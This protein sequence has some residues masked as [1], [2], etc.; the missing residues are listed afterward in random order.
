MK[1]YIFILAAA[2]AVVACKKEQ[3]VQQPVEGK[4]IEFTAT[5]EAPV[6]G[7]VAT[8]GAFTWE[9]GDVAAVYT[10]NG[11]KLD[12]AISNISGATATFTATV[13]DGDAVA[14]GAIVV[15]PASIY[16]ASGKVT[17]PASYTDGKG[18]QG[19]ALVAKVASGNL[20]FKYLTGAIS[21]SISDVPAIATSVSVKTRDAADVADVVCTG[22]YDVDFSG[23]NPALSNP[24]GT[25]SA[26]S[27]TG[28]SEG[29]NS[30]VLPILAGEQKVKLAV[31]YNEDV[32][33]EKAV[34]LTATRNYYAAMPALSINPE[35][36]I[37]ADRIGWNTND[38]PVASL[39][40]TV[41]SA[42]LPVLGK[43]YFRAIVKYGNVEVNYGLET[44]DQ[45][46]AASGNLKVGYDNAVY[47]EYSGMYDIT[48]DYITGAYTLAKKATSPL[49]MIGVNGT[50]AFD[51]STNGFS[52]IENTN[53]LYWK[54]TST[55]NNFK[56]YEKGITDYNAYVYG[57]S[58]TGNWFGTFNADTAGGQDCGMEAN[59]EGVAVFDFRG[60]THTW[61]K[62]ADNA[63][64][65]SIRGDFAA[66][67]AD[68]WQASGEISFEEAVAGTGIW[69][70]NLTLD[71]PAQLKFVVNGN[72]WFGDGQNMNTTP[73]F[74]NLTNGSNNMTLA[75]GTYDIY[76]VA[77]GSK[78]YHVYAR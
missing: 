9:A 25:G 29:A 44:A 53:L 63:T 55:T 66:A 64:S 38:A 39:S 18:L 58:A 13:P 62:T 19:P 20:A 35:V 71:A 22:T 72:D 50:W 7:L 31:K 1:K 10:E 74:I 11:V 26:I 43:R 68:D 73:D 33:L 40:G 78:S 54:G 4:T 56:V 8:G 60:T 52:T 16:G 51:S 30:F 48:F 12:L 37:V 32:L 47:V 2:A 77:N 17:F 45:P 5:V 34:I 27:I 24:T 75:A 65:V 41:A 15:Y 69:H 28:I 23:T 6:K 76:F 3:P 42:E 49:Y 36:Y 21:I 57:A 46:A 61:G 67:D 14:E 59:A 70:K